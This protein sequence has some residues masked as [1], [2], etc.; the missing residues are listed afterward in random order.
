MFSVYADGQ[1]IFMPLDRTLTIHNPK[2]SLEIGKAGSFQF[3]L[4][5][6]NLF[7]N[8]LQ[9]MRSIVTVEYEGVEIFRGR[10]LTNNRSFNNVRSVYCEGDLAYLVDSVQK[11]TKFNGK[12]HDL[13]RK[14][15]EGHNARVDDYKKFTVGNITIEDRDVILSGK[16]EE[17]EKYDVKKFNYKQIAL[18]AIVD[19][20][21]NSF[22]YIEDV[23]IDY[24][25]G[26]LRTRREGNTTYIDYLADYDRTSPQMIEFGTNLLDISE[27]I[28]PD[29]MFTVLIPIGDENLTLEKY[30]G[31]S[32]YG[33]RIRYGGGSDEIVDAEAVARYGR[34]VKTHVFDNVN[35]V[36]TLLE[37]ALR[38]FE[39]HSA[40]KTTYTAKAVDWHLINSDTDSIYVGDKVYVYTPT[41]NLTELLTCTKIE[42]DLANPGNSSYTFGNP[43][44]TL[45]ERY[46]KDKQKSKGGGGGRKTGGGSGA[47]DTAGAVADALDAGLDDMS[48]Y[49]TETAEQTKTD[50]YEAW[51]KVSDDS[52]QVTLGTLHKQMLDGKEY[53]RTKCGIDLDSNKGS[54]DI[55]S[56]NHSIVTQGELLGKEIATSEARFKTLTDDTQA[57][58]KT[59]ADFETATSKSTAEILAKANAN[60]AS[61][62]SLAQWKDT[63]DGKLNSIAKIEQ[64]VNKN[65]SQI[66]LL[67][68]HDNDKASKIAQIELIANNNSSR[69]NLKADVTYVD[70]KIQGALAQFDTL[71][72][73]KIQTDVAFAAKLSAAWIEVG[74][75]IKAGSTITCADLN[76]SHNI[77]A[78][79]TINATNNVYVNWQPVAT[80]SWVN[81]RLGGT[82]TLGANS[83]VNGKFTTGPL[84]SSGMIV[85]ASLWVGSESSKKEVATKSWVNEQLANY[86]K[87]SHTHDFTFNHNHSVTVSGT[88][89]ATTVPSRYT[90]TTGSA[91]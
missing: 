28:D 89:Y 21:M 32:D 13:F 55:Y 25:G 69:I 65:E 85:G 5:S 74:G 70:G 30:K 41:H 91:K 10:V 90:G 51:I 47:G 19:D 86:S 57:L 31:S 43:K 12:A 34:I 16:S 35:K 52:S 42:Y 33:A 4:P 50:I 62:T 38:Y 15:I 88:K 76:A 68:Q 6:S 81:S 22:D 20:W 17:I 82:V 40:M 75:T 71:F 61:I 60:S 14:I 8:K 83:S 72:A 53:L 73:K 18:N 78:G 48:Q 39:E 79:N 24:C 27:E 1:L 67:A 64:T 7:Y 23:L 44:Q 37:N 45:T 29:E 26:Y 54:V 2:V 59:L 63:A 9:Q 49:I 3:E 56:M 87:K 77:N 66:N 80:Q 36:N 58:A 84:V 11:G 46:R